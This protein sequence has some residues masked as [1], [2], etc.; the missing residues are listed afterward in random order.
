MGATAILN[1]HVHLIHVALKIGLPLLRASR[2]W[3]IGLHRPLFLQNPVI[4][5]R[6]QIRLH[7][8]ARM[9]WAHSER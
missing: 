9:R 3:A 6:P 4:F 7:L 1:P 8:N 2:Q 5:H